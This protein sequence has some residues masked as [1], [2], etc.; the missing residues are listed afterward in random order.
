MVNSSNILEL[1]YSIIGT[2]MQ[3][4]DCAGEVVAKLSPE[5]FSSI[6]MRGLYEAISSLHF[7]GNPIDPVTVLQRA[8]EDYEIAV[9]EAMN[10]Y[11]AK[12][13]LPYY[14]DLLLEQGQLHQLQAEAMVMSNAENIQEARE[15]LD[16]LNGMMVNRK[17]VEILDA[18][19]SAV[20][21]YT[22]QKG[23]TPEYLSWGIDALDKTLYA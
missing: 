20:D 13:S 10:H 7:E 17:N 5:H 3:G 22:R 18:S 21:F 12:S 4:A 9:N 14:C 11:T 1:E 6:A 16:R 2:V 8:G 15:A 19:Q 23:P